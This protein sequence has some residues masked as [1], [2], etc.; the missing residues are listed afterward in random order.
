MWTCRALF[1]LKAL[2]HWLF[3]PPVCVRLCLS[4]WLR[5]ANAFA[6]D[7]QLKTLGFWELGEGPGW[8]TRSCS[9]LT[10][11]CVARLKAF[12]QTPQTWQRSFALAFSHRFWIH[13]RVC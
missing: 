13:N 9:F 3:L 11:R 12:L 10:L 6:Q 7:V 2:S 5:F 1:W 4:S 8:C